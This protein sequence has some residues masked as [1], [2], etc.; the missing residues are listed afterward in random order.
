MMMPPAKFWR[1]PLSAMP[2][3][4]PNDASRAA[5]LVVLMPRAPTTEMMSSTCS[6]M[7]T[8]L[9]MKVCTVTSIL[10]RSKKRLSMK[11]RNLMM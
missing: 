7:P 2:T 5:K 11:L 4:T 9:R 10:R 6:T 8:K 1:L 3:A